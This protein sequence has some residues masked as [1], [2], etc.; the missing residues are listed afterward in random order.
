MDRNL[1]RAGIAILAAIS[2]LPAPFF[3]QDQNAG[4]QAM[5]SQPIA[6]SAVQA[7]PSG[8]VEPRTVDLKLDYSVE[9]KWFPDITLPY[10]PMKP[11]EQV[12]HQFPSHRAVDPGRQADA[13][14]A[15]RHLAGPRK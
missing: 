7:A 12:A 5:P 6:R 8:P 1:M 4:G 14:P 3:A 9:R 13:E 15:G 10:K 11:A 2:L